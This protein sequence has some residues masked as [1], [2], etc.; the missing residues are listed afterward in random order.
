MAHACA[1]CESEAAVTDQSP[2]VVEQTLRISASPETVW[3][4]WTDPELMCAWWARAAELD[5]RPG[6]VCWVDIADGG[7]MRGEYVELVPFERIV[8]TF[9]WEK[10]RFT[11]EIP[12]G[13]TLVEVTFVEEAGDTV[14]TLRHSGL[15]PHLIEL[16]HGGWGHHL[17][18]LAAAVQAS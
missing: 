9:G 12:P 2:D 6:G 11:D 10:S 1:C 13:S 8:L 5:P 15:P 16:H 14:M 7:T 17:P 3:R 4:Y 18:M